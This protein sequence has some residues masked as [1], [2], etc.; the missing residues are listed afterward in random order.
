MSVPGGHVSVPLLV[1]ENIRTLREEYLSWV[2]ELGELRLQRG[3]VREILRFDDGFSFWWMTF[4]AQK[5]PMKDPAIYDLFKLRAIEKYYLGNAYRGIILYTGDSLLGMVLRNWCVSIGHPFRLIPINKRERVRKRRRF[6][7]KLPYTVRAL[8]TIAKRYWTRRR[9][10]PPVTGIPKD[11]R[12]ATV[13]TYFPNVDNKLLK[14]GVFRSNYWGRLHDLFERGPWRLNWIWIYTP[15]DEYSFCESIAA[16]DLIMTKSGKKDRH[17]FIEEFM[18]AGVIIKMLGYYARLVLRMNSLKKIRDSFH[19]PGSKL[20][21]WPLFSGEWKNSLIGSEAIDNCLILAT[22]KRL[23]MML[24][25]QEWGLYL[26]ENIVWEKALNH[27]WKNTDNGKIIGYQ[28]TTLRFLDLRFFEDTRSYYL[29]D[30]PP[31]LPT[32]LAVNGKG[33]LSLLE[34]VKF[35][36]HKM[37]VVEAVR[38]MYLLDSIVGKKNS[39]NRKIFLVIT[40]YLY[41]E[42]YPQLELLIQAVRIHGRDLFGTI[43]IKPHPDCPVT[44]ILEE[45]VPDIHFDVTNE[46][47]SELWPKVAVVFVANSSS[48]SAEAV[49]LGVPVMVHVPEN[50]LNYSPLLGNSNVKHVGTTDDLLAGLCLLPPVS[51]G[52]EFFCLDREL[53]QWHSLLEAVNTIPT[54]YNQ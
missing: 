20:D 32:I 39:V 5:N 38:Y 4:V 34:Q 9:H 31:P 40:G 25:R 2:H 52:N 21:F 45:L 35:P 14:E 24:P 42:T 17:F 11:G 19:F 46:P 50:S 1:E 36:S 37:K 10:L 7:E 27:V 18:D 3:S 43:L 53:T 26:W 13:V 12:Q 28:H 6:I 16:R 33:S 15:S 47:L 44:R 23:V 54:K 30:M 48:A 51:I 41:E 29:E 49:Y 22:L 8:A